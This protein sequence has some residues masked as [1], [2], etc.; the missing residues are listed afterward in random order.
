MYI[1][2]I[3]VPLFLSFS[4]ILTSHKSDASRQQSLRVV[5][6]L[7]KALMF[8]RISFGYENLNC[9]LLVPALNWKQ[10]FL[11]FFAQCESTCIF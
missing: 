7:I 11:W 5:S 8:H 4:D 6:W 2:F 3:S 10:E 9:S 1:S